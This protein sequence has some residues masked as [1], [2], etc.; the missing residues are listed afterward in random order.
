M[1]ELAILL[2]SP[3]LFVTPASVNN[4]RLRCMNAFVMSKK[5]FSLVSLSHR[6]HWSYLSHRSHCLI[7]LIGLTVSSFSLVSLSHDINAFVMPNKL[8]A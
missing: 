8:K 3:N 2:V 4:D 5:V 7:V 6:S 1:T